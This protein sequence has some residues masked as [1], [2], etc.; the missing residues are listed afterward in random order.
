MVGKNPQRLNLMNR[1]KLTQKCNE[2]ERMDNPEPQSRGS[3]THKR[4]GKNAIV[5]ALGIEVNKKPAEGH[6][7]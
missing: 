5:W 1:K 2:R 3:T 4:S 6:Q 7:G